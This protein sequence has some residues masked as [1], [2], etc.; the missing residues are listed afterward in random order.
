MNIK[1]QK[2]GFMYPYR[3]RKVSKKEKPMRTP[4]KNSSMPFMLEKKP[5]SNKGNEFSKNTQESK[6]FHSSAPRLPKGRRE[7]SMSQNYRN[8]EVI[9]TRPRNSS[10]SSMRS[11]RPVFK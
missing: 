10:T 8:H 3:S 2:K 1:T 11:E 4:T 5:V 7:H 9:C 6:N